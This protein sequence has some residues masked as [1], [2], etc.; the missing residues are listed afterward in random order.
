M[1][2]QSKLQELGNAPSAIVL[3]RGRIVRLDLGRLRLPEA[4]VTD[5]AP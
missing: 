2:S 5:L 3:S 4:L 1:F